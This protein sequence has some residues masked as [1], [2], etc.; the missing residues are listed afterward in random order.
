MQ[1]TPTPNILRYPKPWVCC[2]QRLFFAPKP[3]AGSC[4]GGHEIVRLYCLQRRTLEGWLGC[5]ATELRA[6]AVAVD[7]KNGKG[8]AGNAK[9]W[10]P[11]L[12]TALVFC[13]A[14]ANF[15]HGLGNVLARVRCA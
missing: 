12:I 11:R 4:I 6:V 15:V 14:K 10:L 2:A 13:Q 7:L 3:A 1:P 5:A 9:I 8:P